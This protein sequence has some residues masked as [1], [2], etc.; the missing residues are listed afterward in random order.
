MQLQLKNYCVN[1]SIIIGLHTSVRYLFTCQRKDSSW[2]LEAYRVLINLLAKFLVGQPELSSIKIDWRWIIFQPMVVTSSGESRDENPSVIVASFPFPLSL[3][4]LPLAYTFSCA[5]WGVYLQANC[6]HHNSQDLCLG[7]LMG[8]LRVFLQMFLLPCNWLISK[9][10]YQSLNTSVYSS[11]FFILDFFLSDFED[12]TC[13]GWFL[14]SINGFVESLEKLNK[15]I[16]KWYP[17]YKSRDVAHQKLS[18]L[19]LLMSDES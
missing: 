8:K 12:L 3:V 18:D 9:F 19:N 6:W 17:H 2:F 4:A 1:I 7:C 14:T 13:W 16:L 5:K 15:L 11:I 10:V